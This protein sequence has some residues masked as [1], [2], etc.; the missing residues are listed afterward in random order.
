MRKPKSIKRLS[1]FSV[2]VGYDKAGAAK[3]ALIRALAIS[4]YKNL[5]KLV[6]DALNRIYPN[7]G[8]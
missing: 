1:S 8:L 7:L 4:Q 5:S 2:Y 3:L 6:L